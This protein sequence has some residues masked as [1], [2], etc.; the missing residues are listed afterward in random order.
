MTANRRIALNI[1]ATY[2]RSLYA[3]ILGLFTARWALQALGHVDYGL[4]GVVG[5]LSAFIAFFNNILSMGVGRFYAVS[6][7]K[8]SVEGSELEGLEDCR[9]WF[10]TAVALHTCVAVLLMSV[11]YPVGAWVINNFLTIPWDRLDDCL[12]VFRFVCVTC[13]VGMVTVPVNAMYTAKQYIA[14]L[15]IYSFATTTLKVVFLYYMVSHPGVWLKEYAC[16]I[17]VLSTLPQLIIMIRGCVIFQECRIRFRY[18]FSTTRLRSLVYYCGW[19]ALGAGGALLRA[20]GV[21]VLI[22]KY[23]GP[24]VNSAM[25]VASS[26][27]GHTITLSGSL[28]GAFSPAIANAYGAGDLDRMR[29]LAYRACK[30]G[31]LL[32]LLFVVPLSLE[33]RHL[34]ELWLV[35][36]PRYV[37]GLCQV[38][39][40]M[41][42]IDQLSVGHMLA[43]NAR[44][45]I[46]WYQGFLGTSLILTLPLAW[47]FCVCG[48]NVYWV[49]VAMLLT[50]TFCSLGRVWFARSLVGMSSTFW[51]KRIAVPIL[52]VMF[53]S[54][55]VGS[56]PQLFMGPVFGRIIVTSIV[57]ESV[58]VP[59]ALFAVLD[60]EERAYLLA[61]V[62]FV[63]RKGVC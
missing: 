52:I 33:L 4:Y 19:T 10:S 9:K 5:G 22:N 27:N 6:V 44:G 31:T 59:M 58:F 16:L 43:V 48:A 40:I 37:Y 23:F 62:P 8:I 61:R 1:I 49:A 54:Y 60:T 12:C 21:Q 15:T 46:A 26:V 53:F 13:F 51:L 47:I 57:C 30:F 32:V 45:Q 50:M 39:F 63:G 7:G 28:L 18:V 20:Q 2:G 38:M 14:E 29:A 42:I 34:L 11:G 35:K 36:P 55:F 56:V 41:S 24:R 17:C 3:L 25:T